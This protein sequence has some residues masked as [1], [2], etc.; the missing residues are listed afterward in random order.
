VS[1]DLNEDG[2]LDVDNRKGHTERYYEYVD[3]NRRRSKNGKEFYIQ[4]PPMTDIDMLMV[5]LQ[6]IKKDYERRSKK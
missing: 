4:I 1:T 5:R 2:K 6:F 3:Y